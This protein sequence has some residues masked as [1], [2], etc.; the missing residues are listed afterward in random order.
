MTLKNL[1]GDE[2]FKELNALVKRNIDIRNIN[3][4]FE[5]RK[6]AIEL[7]MEWIGSVY[8]L[9]DSQQKQIEDDETDLSKL[10]KIR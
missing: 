6:K 9:T 3:G 2:A 10:F 7:L 8:S 4:D 5:I 1:L